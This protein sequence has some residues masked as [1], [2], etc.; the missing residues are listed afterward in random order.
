MV[1]SVMV[2]L[3][4]CSVAEMEQ[5]RLEGFGSGA[6]V[7][8]SCCSGGSFSMVFDLDLSPLKGI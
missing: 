4:H 5:G 7:C 1:L 8:S 2:V 3:L 6:L